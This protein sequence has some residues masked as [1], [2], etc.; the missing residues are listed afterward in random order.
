MKLFIL[1][2]AIV[3]ICILIISLHTWAEHNNNWTA[4]LFGLM[5]ILWV[6]TPFVE[7]FVNRN[8]IEIEVGRE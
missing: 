6:I 5:G 2:N 4:T 7:L 8:K 1:N 3:K